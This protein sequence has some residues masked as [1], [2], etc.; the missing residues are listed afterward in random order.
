MWKKNCKVKAT[1]ASND[2]Q[3]TWANIEGMGW[4]RIKEGSS[5]G[6]CNIFKI[7]CTAKSRDRPV[8]VEVDRENLITTAY[9]L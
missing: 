7:M 2:P 4:R 3:W 5:D 6:V 1:F 8:H 9:L